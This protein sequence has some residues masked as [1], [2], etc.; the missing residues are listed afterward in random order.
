MIARRINQR[1]E[2]RKGSLQLAGQ[3]FPGLSEPSDGHVAQSHDDGKEGI[4]ILELFAAT[5]NNWIEYK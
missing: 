5:T 2:L 4:Q 1:L 3:T